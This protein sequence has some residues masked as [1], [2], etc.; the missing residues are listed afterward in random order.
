MQLTAPVVGGAL[1]QAYGWRST[2]AGLAIMCSVFG[3]AV[4]V[5]M[6]HE[7]H[8]YYVLQRLAKKD[9]CAAARVQEWSSIMSKKPNFD[10]P[11]MPFK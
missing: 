3:L 8:H 10:A 6:R 9:A 2:F 1:C 5:L 7:T 11:W 4:L